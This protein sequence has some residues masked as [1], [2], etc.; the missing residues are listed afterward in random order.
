MCNWLTTYY[1]EINLKMKCIKTKQFLVGLFWKFPDFYLYYDD[2]KINRSHFGNKIW[3]FFFQLG[4]LAHQKHLQEF[5]EVSIASIVQEHGREKYYEKFGEYEFI[6]EL[7]EEVK[8]K[9]ANFEAHY[10]AV[11]KYGLLREFRQ[12]FG[13]NVI[14]NSLDEKYNYKKMDRFEIQAYWQSKVSDIALG[15]DAPIKNL[16]YLILM[17]CVNLL[18]S[19]MKS[20]IMECHCITAIR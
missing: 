5:D 8:N 12:L 3:D 16:I 2:N 7:M 17:K 10:E 18:R 14:D 19:W 13:D 4:R 11:K 9:K 15:N 20:Q 1:Q 6:S